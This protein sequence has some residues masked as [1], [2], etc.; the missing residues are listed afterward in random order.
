MALNNQSGTPTPDAATT[1]S[2]GPEDL[3]SS[4]GASAVALAMPTSA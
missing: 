1:D 4:P 2:S 3:E